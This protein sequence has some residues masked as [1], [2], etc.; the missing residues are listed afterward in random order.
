MTTN[1]FTESNPV[2]LM[3]ECDFNGLIKRYAEKDINIGGYH[4]EG[5]ILSIGTPGT[6]FNL[7]SFKLNAAEINV[8]IVNDDNLHNE[9]SR[10]VL[11]GSF[12]RVYAYQD[13]QTWST[14]STYN[15]IYTGVFKKNYHTRREYSFTIEDATMRRMRILP[16]SYIKDSSFPSH[17]KAGGGGSVSGK[18]LPIIFG[19]FDGGIPLLCVDTAGYKYAVASGTVKSDDADYT[20]TTENVYDKDGAVVAAAGFTM[21]IGSVSDSGTYTYFDFTGDQVASESLSCSIKGIT[22]GSGEIVGTAGGLLEKIDE[23]YQYIINQYGIGIS[24]HLESIGILRVVWNGIK[25]GMYINKTTS[26][27]DIVDRMLGQ[28]LCSRQIIDGELGV[29]VFDTDATTVRWFNTEIDHIGGDVTLSKTNIDNVCNSLTVNYA[30]NISSGQYEGTIT[31]DRGNNSDCERSYYQYGERPS[32][33]LNLTDIRETS[34]AEQVA[35]KYLKVHSFRHD[36][37]PVTMLYSD[38]YGI[39]EGFAAKWTVPE[40]PSGDGAGWVDEKFIL[41][42]RKFT[43]NGIIQRWWRVNSN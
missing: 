24:P 5:K 12:C 34:M 8:V 38:A 32:V 29:M 25:I 13:D 10:R 17:R 1:K 33:I 14:V 19:A 31:F 43:K 37:L 30:L 15:L 6:T 36:I 39:R 35:R 28:V 41:L 26:A 23:V 9:E 22:D 27:A 7:R 42:D 3:V 40:G 16:D 11:D 21:Y 2:F 4:F 18:T 20:A